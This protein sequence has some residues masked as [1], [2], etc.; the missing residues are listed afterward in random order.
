MNEPNDKENTQNSS[1]EEFEC[2]SLLAEL[3]SVVCHD[4]E[5]HTLHHTVREYHSADEPCPA[6]ARYMKAIRNAQ[7][8][9]S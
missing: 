6:K 8:F 2:K 9:L 1:R 5:C 3:L 7:E 4:P